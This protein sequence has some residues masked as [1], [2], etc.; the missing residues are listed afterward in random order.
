[1]ADLLNTEFEHGFCKIGVQYSA[2][3]LKQ[4]SEQLRL[5][6]LQKEGKIAQQKKEAQK[7]ELKSSFIK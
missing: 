5:L 6:H 4:F 1:M 2:K 3:Q 7:E